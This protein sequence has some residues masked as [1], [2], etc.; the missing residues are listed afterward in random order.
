MSHACSW[1]DFALASALSRLWG[2]GPSLVFH[3]WYLSFRISLWTFAWAA[4]SGRWNIVGRFLLNLWPQRTPIHSW[5]ASACHT[6]MHTNIHGNTHTT[7][8]YTDIDTHIHTCRDSGRSWPAG[9]FQN[10][11]S[12]LASLLHSLMF[13]NKSFNQIRKDPL[14][15]TPDTQMGLTPPNSPHPFR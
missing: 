8:I 15:L 13:G 1:W 5:L 6:H 3:P 12:A 11:H 14:F 2:L 9:P 10:I 7:H 4:L